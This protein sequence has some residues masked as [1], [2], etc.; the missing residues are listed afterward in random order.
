M[1]TIRS[2]AV[3]F[4]L[5]ALALS[6]PAQNISAGFAGTRSALDYAYGWPGVTASNLAIAPN[7]GNVIKPFSQRG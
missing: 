1:K 7:G 3:V 6:L 4:S 5:F 2:I